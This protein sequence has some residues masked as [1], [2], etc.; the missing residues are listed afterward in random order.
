MA[1]IPDP[2]DANQPI[3]TVFASTAAAEFRAIKAYIAGI[4]SAGYPPV[5]GLAG[6][7][8]VV[9]PT[10]GITWSA[11]PSLFAFNTLT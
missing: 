7:S 5:T 4:A 3:G 8:L 9:T 2:T 10:G 1:Y 6:N 11:V